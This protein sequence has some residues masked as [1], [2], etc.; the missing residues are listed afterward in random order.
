MKRHEAQLHSSETPYQCRF[1]IWH[2]HCS[3]QWWKYKNDV[4][5]FRT[6][7]K[8]LFYFSRCDRTFK[9]EYSWKRHQSNDE[10][11]QK[12]ENFTPFLT[13][14]VIF[15]LISSFTLFFRFAGSSLRGGGGGAWISTCSAMRRRG[16]S[17]V[18]S[19]ENS[20]GTPHI[21]E[22]IGRHALEWRYV[23]SNFMLLHPSYSYYI[24][25]M[26]QRQKDFYRPGGRV[27]LLWK[28]VCSESSADKP[29]ANP[30]RWLKLKAWP[31]N[32]ITGE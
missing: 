18:T 32:V 14:E 9:S 8:R 23:I 6:A 17:T 30:H 5:G 27:C 29:R 25:I 2:Q 19:V 7:I 16:S 24:H 10:V 21:W 12:M 13:C 22:H 3:F 28:E 11:H 1:T 15:N 4:V 20:S 26:P 31:Y